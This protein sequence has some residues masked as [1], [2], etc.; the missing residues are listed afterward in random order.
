MT[1]PNFG[2]MTKADKEKLDAISLDNFLTE[3]VAN[4]T[5][6]TKSAAADTYVTKTYAQQYVLQEL[7]TPQAT[8]ITG[9]AS[10]N[11]ITNADNYVYIDALGGTDKITNSGRYVT[12]DGGEGN[13]TITNSGDYVSIYGGMG[14]E[15][16]FNTGDYITIGGGTGAL[17]AFDDGANNVYIY[18]SGDGN[19]TICGYT[20]SDTLVIVG[21]DITFEPTSLGYRGTTGI[22]NTILLKGQRIEGNTN[23]NLAAYDY[24]PPLLGVNISKDF[25]A[26]TKSPPSRV[27]YGTS[28]DDNIVNSYSNI[29]ISVGNGNDT[30]TNYGDYVTIDGGFSID[31]I[32]NSGDYVS[33]VGGAGGGAIYNSGND[34]FIRS[35]RGRIFNSGSRNT[36]SCFSDYYF[37]ATFDDGSKNVF[38]LPYNKSGTA[39][40]SGWSNPTICGFSADDTLSWKSELNIIGN[41][42]G[43][44]QVQ[45]LSTSQKN[46]YIY[47]KG[48]RVPGTTEYSADNF[49]SIKSGS[50]IN[51]YNSSS[52]TLTQIQVP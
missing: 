9:T 17:R 49:A 43:G 46:V 41:T 30:V 44:L 11:T 13:D 2:L 42:A 39:Y 24:L 16:V 23:N 33:I 38:V 26:V 7:S 12:I 36:L 48:E 15:T 28:S 52:K 34:S 51:F 6:I 31:T 40:D 8:T 14:N 19:Q 22:G 10:A 1:L 37:G 32:T 27:W 50:Y 47:I 18:H 4:E 29:L 5:Y 45:V 3:A 25:G 21:T 35:K 20:G